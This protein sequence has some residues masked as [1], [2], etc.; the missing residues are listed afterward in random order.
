MVNHSGNTKNFHC[1]M[2]N[3]QLETTEEENDLDVLINQD[4]YKLSREIHLQQRQLQSVSRE[5]FSVEM[6]I[7]SIHFTKNW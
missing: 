6:G 5:E 1:N 7:Y 2:K 4:E 3:S